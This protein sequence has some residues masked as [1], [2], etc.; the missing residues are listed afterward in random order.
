MSVFYTFDSWLCYYARPNLCAGCRGVNELSRL[1]KT[2]FEFD[3]NRT[4]ACLL[5]N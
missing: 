2:R 1:V 5:N 4:R 3:V